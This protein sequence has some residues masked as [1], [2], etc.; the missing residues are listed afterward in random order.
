MHKE[1]PNPTEL[2]SMETPLKTQIRTIT[3]ENEE[4][5]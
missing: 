2:E 4:S 5:E 3:R 1:Q